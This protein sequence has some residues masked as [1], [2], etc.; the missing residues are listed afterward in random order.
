MRVGNCAGLLVTT[1]NI[2]VICFCLHSTL[3]LF[4]QSL[5]SQNGNLHRVA[6]MWREVQLIFKRYNGIH[7]KELM[8]ME[9]IFVICS[10]S[11]AAYPL[12]SMYKKLDM[13]V[14]LICG[15]VWSIS[16]LA[17]RT[18]L[19][20]PMKVFADGEVIVS[21]KGLYKLFGESEGKSKSLFKSCKNDA[22]LISTSL[23]R[24]YWDSLPKQ[25]IYFFSNNFFE[26]KTPLVILDFA[27]NILVN[28]ILI[29]E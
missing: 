20:L 10:F 29:Q 9:I 3:L 14:I 4:S 25:K 22:K 1:L 18:C 21:G 17:M 28:L 27:I 8:P 23:A 11:G 26:R 13:I 6:K 19:S 16:L 24:K 15:N 12:I 5:P 7:Q 2:L